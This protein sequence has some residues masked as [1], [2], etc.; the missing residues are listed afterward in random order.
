VT[1][2][3]APSAPFGDAQLA[4]D[5]IRDYAI[6]LLKPDGTVASWNE[7]ARVIKGYSASEI[8]GQSFTRFY[9]PEDARSGKPLRLLAQAANEGRVEEEG[10]RVRKDG[11]RFWA[12]VVITAVRGPDGALQGF[13]KIT[14]DLTE[15]RA[16][17]EAVR[18]AEER[19]RQMVDSIKD[20]AIFLLDPTGRV[21][22][23]NT[24]AERLKGYAAHEIIGHSFARFYPEEEVRAGKPARELAIAGSEGRFEEEGWRVRKDGSRFWANVILSAVRD[25][26][27]ELVG[28]TKV[29]RDMTDRKRADEL[30]LERARQQAAVAQLGVFAVEQTEFDAVVR[31]A[32]GVVHETLGAD[33]AAQLLEQSDDGS[34]LV[35][36]A[37]HG[38]DPAAAGRTAGPVGAES[39]A[40]H[41]LLTAEAARFDP[42]RF[43]ADA[44]FGPEVA[45]GMTVVVRALGRPRGAYG[46]L[47]AHTGEQRAFTEDDLHFLQSVANVLSAAT[48]RLRMEQQIRAAE[49]RAQREHGRAAQAREALRDRDEFISVAAH[50]LRTPLTALQLKL[51][52]LERGLKGEGLERRAP[53]KVEDRL[54]G[55]L[56]QTERLSHLIERLLDVTRVTSGRLELSPEWFDLAELVS[57]VAEDFREPA[58]A[59]GSELRLDGTERL[60]GS[61]DRLRME[62][63]L[64]NLLS[65]AVKY[66]AGRPISLRLEA[67]GDRIRIAVA[68]EGIGISA[69]DLGRIFTRFERA[70]PV[71]NYG[72]L[73]L[74]LY[75]TRH[76]VEAHGGRIDVSSQPGQGSTF[77][78]DL[79]RAGVHPNP[80][81]KDPRR[82]RA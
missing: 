67:A 54:E 66:G 53:A 42:R 51:Q 63:V 57:Q 38:V 56:R 34:S 48:E 14:R 13:V 35:L 73:G 70:A 82:A 64:V 52:G 58:A 77:I 71:R 4:I 31:R 68:D 59:A 18:Q 29:T 43:R 19:I 44:F 75:I 9:T 65:N 20:Y 32:I 78:V 40:G 28:F 5:G 61:W 76:I 26:R 15:R 79:P 39:Q 55:A 33:V 7:G 12:D 36:R 2:S 25:G 50:E 10:W 41:T 17:E 80:P 47:A 46:V 74:G 21:A 81:S 8:V 30:V 23:W 6:F 27:G 11:S 1:E 72:G 37:G 24:G 3:R 49:E 60:E 69:A 45:A 16:A 62:Q 22:S